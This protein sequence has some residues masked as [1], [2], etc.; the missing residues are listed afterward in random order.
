M[1]LCLQSRSAG[2]GSENFSVQLKAQVQGYFKILSHFTNVQ[3]DL[4]KS[5][6]NG[7]LVEVTSV[8][9]H[10]NDQNLYPE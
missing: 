3:C 1:F 10:E 6:K 2:T 7:V 4:V 8:L 9:F 5:S